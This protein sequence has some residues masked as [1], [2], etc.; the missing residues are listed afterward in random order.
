[1]DAMLKRRDAIVELIEQRGAN[2]VFDSK[3]R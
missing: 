2:A 1:M 3:P